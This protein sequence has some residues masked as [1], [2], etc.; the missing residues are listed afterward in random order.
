M[1]FSC[2]EIQVVDNKNFMEVLCFLGGKELEGFGGNL[3][4]EVFLIS[5]ERALEVVLRCF[6]KVTGTTAHIQ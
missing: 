1:W 3:Q 4:L 6:S 2:I 5:D